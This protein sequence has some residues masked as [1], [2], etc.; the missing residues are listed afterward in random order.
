MA[1]FN[2][3]REIHHHHE[4]SMGTILTI[5]FVVLK[6]TGSIDLSWWWVLLTH[7]DRSGDHPA[8]HGH[9]VDHVVLR[10]QVL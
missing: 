1:L 6:L 4:P 3:D 2:S 8:H 9:H 5:V 10:R 7:L